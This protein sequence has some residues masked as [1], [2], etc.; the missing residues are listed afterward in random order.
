MRTTNGDEAERWIIDPPVKTIA[1]GES[2]A[3]TSDYPDVSNAIGSVNLAFI[4]TLKN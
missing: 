1:A 4:P 2:F 3:F